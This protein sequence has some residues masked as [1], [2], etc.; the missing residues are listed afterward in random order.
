MTSRTDYFAEFEEKYYSDKMTEEE[1]SKKLLGIISEEKTEKVLNLEE[2]ED[3]LDY[4]EL[5]KLKEYDNFRKLLISM[6]VVLVIL[7][8]TDLAES[9]LTYL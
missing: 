1:K 8:I 9:K 2:Y 5:Y 4:E 7:S 6:K 3:K